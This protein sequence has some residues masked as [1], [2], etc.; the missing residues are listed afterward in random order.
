MKEFEWHEEKALINLKKHNVDFNEAA[1]VFDDIFSIFYEDE[2][3]SITELRFR[4]LGYSKFNRLL[5]VTFTERKYNNQIV[6]R[7]I[8][9][10]L[11][12]KYER[13]IYESKNKH[14]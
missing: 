6:T 9:A 5:S 10:R 3:H 13:K 11:A 4:L 14:N 1:S 12:T 2:E 7:I 8:N